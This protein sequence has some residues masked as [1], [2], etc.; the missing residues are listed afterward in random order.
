MRQHSTGSSGRSAACE[1]RLRRMRKKSGSVD[2]H[3]PAPDFCL[4]D[5]EGRNVCLRD[6]R[7][8]THVLLVFNRGFL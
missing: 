7:G 6:Y 3:V 2:L 8:S 1:E 4:P 5:Y